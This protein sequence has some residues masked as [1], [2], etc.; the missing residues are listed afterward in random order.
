MPNQPHPLS[1][2]RVATVDEDLDIKDLCDSLNTLAGISLACENAIGEL[3]NAPT[4]FTPNDPMLADQYALGATNGGINPEGAWGIT[5]G[6]TDIVIAIIDSGCNVTHED[7]R[8]NIWVN[9]GEIPSNG[10]DDDGNGFIDDVNGWNFAES[11]NSLEDTGS[12]GTS[13]SGCAAARIDN[14]VGIAGVSNSSIMTANIDGDSTIADCTIASAVYYAVDSGAHVLNL[15]LQFSDP[16][17]LTED[18]VN[19]AHANGVTVVAASGNFGQATLAYPAR[20]ANVIAVGAIQE[21]GLR[22]NDSNYGSELDVVAPG[23]A[24]LTPLSFNN[25]IPNN[26]YWTPSGTSFACPQVAGLAALMLSVNPT[27]TPAEIRQKIRE[28]A[29]DLGPSGFDNEFG[30]GLINVTDTLVSA[31][32]LGDVNRDGVANFLDYAPFITLSSSNEYQYEADI[33]CDGLVNFLDIV[34]LINNLL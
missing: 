9:D 13:V 25:N 8:E 14:G 6:S 33:N 34:P 23:A 3:A 27:L 2:V 28:N 10:V 15:S 1:Y 24:V 18:A 29:V 32:T 20:Y 19:F 7:L 26:L 17:P 31:A 16:I 5:T 21:G 11:N 30:Y 4:A 12:H 22:W